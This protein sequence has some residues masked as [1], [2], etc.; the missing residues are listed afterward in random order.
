MAF[1]TPGTAV[2][3]SVLTSAFWNTNVRDNTNAIRAAQ[4]NLQSVTKK[5]VQILAVSDNSFSANISGLEVTI[6]PSAS[7]SNIFV[8]GSLSALEGS[9][10]I[11][12]FGFRIMRNTTPVGIADA[13]GSRQRVTSSSLGTTASAS[14]SIPFFHLDNPGSTSAITYGIQIFNPSGSPRNYNINSGTTDADGVQTIRAVSNITV[15]EIPT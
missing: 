13:A 15:M 7:T 4:V 9:A 14:L 11:T 3:G 5:D 6:T 1:T 12:R 2:A 8:M 10:S